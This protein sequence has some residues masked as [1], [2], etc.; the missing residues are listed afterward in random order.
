[1]PP[2]RLLASLG[3]PADLGGLPTRVRGPGVAA[4]ASEATSSAT[5][6]RRPV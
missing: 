1:M 2:W 6:L 3:A 5:G 4:Q